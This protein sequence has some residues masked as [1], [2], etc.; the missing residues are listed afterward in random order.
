M[1]FHYVVPNTVRQFTRFQS[2]VSKMAFP[3]WVSCVSIGVLLFGTAILTYGLSKLFEWIVQIFI[4]TRITFLVFI[5]AVLL[6]YNFMVRVVAKKMNGFY[7]KYA[8]YEQDFEF[9]SQTSIS[10]RG[11]SINE[12]D[13]QTHMAWTAIGGV[14]QTKAFIVFYCRGLFYHIPLETVGG[15]EAQ[16]E[17]YQACKAWQFAAQGDATAKAFI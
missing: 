15:Q 8:R 13:R 9:T 14:Y 2:Q 17:L 12:G 16:D 10:N 7:L 3:F 4:T 1:E 6:A 11:I 5:P